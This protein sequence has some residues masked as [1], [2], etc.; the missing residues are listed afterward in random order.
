[1]KMIGRT[2]AAVLTALT[3]T[4]A[5]ADAQTVRDSDGSWSARLSD[6]E[7]DQLHIRVTRWDQDSR[8]ES[9]LVLD[10]R[11]ERELLRQLSDGEGDVRFALVAHLVLVLGESVMRHP[12][13]H[14][15]LAA[16]N[17]VPPIAWT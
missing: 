9:S 5:N 17:N 8:W 12:T 16:K 14:A 1:M 3:L 2:M 11:T 4:G 10:E 13:A 15:S 7:T 6:S